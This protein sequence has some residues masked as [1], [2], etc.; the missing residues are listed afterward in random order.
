ML[1]TKQA[2]AMLGITPRRTQDLVKTGKLKANKI[3]GVWLIDEDSVNARLRTVSRTGGRPRRGAGAHDH[4]FTLMNRTHEV[5]T[6]VYDTSR[7]DFT[8]IGHDVDLDHAPLGLA[9]RGEFIPLDPFRAWWRGRGIPSARVGLANLLKTAQVQVPEELIQRNLGLSLSDQYW[10][11]PE[12]SS[13][14]WEDINFFNNAFD[15]VSVS[16]SPFVVTGKTAAAK[17]DNTSDG[18]LEKYWTC[19]GLRRVLHK[20]GMHLNQEPFNEV[21]ASALHR[22]ILDNGQFIPYS[23]E[24]EGTTALSVCDVFLTDEEEYVPAIYINEI[25]TVNDS[26]TEY[27]RYI[28]NCSR[29]GIPDMKSALD[30]MIVCDDILANR[31]RHWRNFGIIRNVNTLACRPAPIFDSGSSLWCD[32]STEALAKGE[33]SFESAQFYPSPA[34]Q[35]LLVEDMSWFD[36]TKLEG[37]VDEAIEVLSKNDALTTRLPFIRESLS[38]RIN[39]MIDIAEWS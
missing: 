13:L 36:S 17:P 4:V 28:E 25:D 10:I 14:K 35:M 16:I 18:N 38:W 11:R 33:H 34:K 20:S 23:L 19:E 26:L 2:A 22:R 3:S 1:T 32:I 7:K 27:E 12:G 24:G 39:R 29:L 9:K 21:V 37:F 30:R 8:S 31:D 5:T 15:K 6:L